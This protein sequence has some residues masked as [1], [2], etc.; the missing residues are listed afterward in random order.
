MAGKG[1]AIKAKGL[2][3]KNL[4]TVTGAL[5]KADAEKR[6]TNLV[7]D[8]GEK[9]NAHGVGNTYKK[10]TGQLD[11]TLNASDFTG[12]TGR[13]FDDF[14]NEVA[15][16]VDI[17]NPSSVIQNNL[18]DALKTI[19]N[20]G[21]SPSAVDLA[22]SKFSLQNEMGSIYRKLNKDLP[23]SDKEQIIYSL[24]KTIDTAL[25]EVYLKQCLS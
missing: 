12:D 25:K 18:D 11:D 17:Q 10:L 15:K 6:I 22:K 3:L 5:D 4:K 20:L 13:L 1:T 7:N 21:T 23:L 9:T 2:G 8:F 14:T 16:N 24:H 19:D